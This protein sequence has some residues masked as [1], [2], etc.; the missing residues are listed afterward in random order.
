MATEA[1]PAGT[2][3]ALRALRAARRRRFVERLDLMEILYR[4]YVVA[5]FGS[6]ALFLV[7]G[8]ID[9]AALGP[10]ALD[11]L[12]EQGPA[13]LGL[14]VALTVLAGLRSGS[15]GGPLA[16]E[17]AE[18]Q[19]VLLAPVDRGVVLRPA[20]FRQ[21]G[22]MALAGSAIGLTAGAFAISRLPGSSFE[23][24]AVLTAF[25]G[26][27]PL[28]YLGAALL[29]S[30][31]RL[32]PRLAAVLGF[33]LLAWTGADLV[34]GWTTSPATMLGALATLPL[35]GGVA[36][37]AAA[38]V[39]AAVAIFVAG[40]A[41]AGGL[42]LD[43]ARRRATLASELRFSAAVQ[44]LRAV[45]L[46]R[47]QL[48]SERPRR[49]PWL[50]AT[51]LHRYLGSPIDRRALRSLL[52]WP[53][54]R[55]LRIAA[56][57]VLAGLVAAGTWAGTTPLVAVVG[58]ILLVAALDLIEPLAQEI[59]HPTRRDLLPVDAAELV[60]RHLMMPALAMT[61]VLAI[62]ALAV[63]ALGATNADLAVV[64]VTILPTALLLAC[65]AALSTT[66]DPYR[67]ILTPYVGYAQTGAP[68]AIAMVA[69]GA[70]LLAA[71]EATRHGYSPMAAVILVEA[72]LLVVA[73]GLVWFVGTRVSA[74]AEVGQ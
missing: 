35:Q 65:C 17:A 26:L 63:L 12:A 10:A 19:H 46:L 62:A 66:N 36:T 28:S 39:A 1:K 50:K 42:S 45:I 8:A 74:R 52:R 54:A 7:A 49:R 23:W 73:V 11:R 6:I 64:A 59:D 48:A 2:M 20:A 53:A 43:L 22:V 71:R 33:G 61:I 58:V 25:G 16:I 15:R 57:G 27:L 30:G 31:W 60:R 24:I 44:D 40:L 21:A 37:T 47:R 29:A 4:A 32:A 51:S 38:G 14:A 18:V 68:I 41:S 34:L 69:G 5:I 72:A 13:A 55:L 56:V 67:Y 70:P 9:D 3:E